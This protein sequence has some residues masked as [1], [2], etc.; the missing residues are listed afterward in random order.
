MELSV[1]A[2]QA[3]DQIRNAIG[4]DHLRKLPMACQREL[5]QRGTDNGAILSCALILL[6]AQLGIE[7]ATPP[8]PVAGMWGAGNA[9]IPMG[10]TPTSLS[11]PPKLPAT[12]SSGHPLVMRRRGPM[13]GSLSTTEAEKL[14]ARA[15]VLL[16]RVGVPA[17]IYRPARMSPTSW[18]QFLDGGSLRHDTA[19]RLRAQIEIMQDAKKAA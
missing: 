14:R 10:A 12:I 8:G 1:T 5:L 16:A 4:I 9:P 3:L 13:A 18:K 17:R 15:R 2:R 11:M 7:L 6:A 19:D